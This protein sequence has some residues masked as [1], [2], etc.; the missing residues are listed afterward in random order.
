MTFL[1][2]S[3]AKPSSLK[4]LRIK[5]VFPQFLEKDGAK[6]FNQSQ[7]KNLGKQAIL[8]LYSI[9]FAKPTICQ[10]SYYHIFFKSVNVLGE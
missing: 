1:S 5:C 6:L 2:K 8:S 3:N 9:L 10:T 4:L 7:R